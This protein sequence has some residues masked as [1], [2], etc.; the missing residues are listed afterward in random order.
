VLLVDLIVIGLAITLQPVPLLAFII[1]LASDGGLRKGAAFLAGWLSSLAAMIAITILATGDLPPRHKTGPSTGAQLAKLCVGIILLALA[2]VVAWR[3]RR[4]PRAKVIPSWQQKVDSMSAWFAF[5]L[6]VL[7][8][9]WPLVVAGIATIVEAKL[10]SL[11]SVLAIIGF[12]LLSTASI[13]VLELMRALQPERSTVRISA[14][15]AWIDLQAPELIIAASG[16][17]GLYLIITSA[18][19]LLA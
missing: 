13:I 1:V 3:R 8:Q 12:C 16:V 14:F 9:P 10:D 2:G 7:I 17:A 4:P 11:G 15:R 18:I 19:R 6:G 5:G